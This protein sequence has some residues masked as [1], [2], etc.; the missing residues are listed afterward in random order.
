[1]LLVRAINQ[2]YRNPFLQVC[3]SDQF[4]ALS[5]SVHVCFYEKKWNVA[6]FNLMCKRCFC[7]PQGLVQRSFPLLLVWAEWGPA[8][9]A[10]PQH[11][12]S[13]HLSGHCRGHT[14]SAQPGGVYGAQW[15]GEQWTVTASFKEWR[16]HG[17]VFFFFF[18]FTTFSFTWK[19]RFQSFLCFTHRANI[20]VI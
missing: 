8:G 19:W 5:N 10:H 11:R 9:W 13:P 3:E 16:T 17:N 2:H 20:V 6:L 7:G 18:S 1:M 14:D 4:A 12:V 15:Q